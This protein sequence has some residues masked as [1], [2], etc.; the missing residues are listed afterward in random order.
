MYY[1]NI[2]KIEFYLSK[3]ELIDIVNEEGNL[4]GE[5]ELREIVHK[6]GLL[7]SAV[8]VLVY[9]SKNKI[10]IQKRALIKDFDAGKWDFV[11]GG[12]LSSGETK[13]Q[14]VLKEL[15]QEYGIKITPN[16]LEFFRK[17]RFLLKVPEKNWFD[18]EINYIY[19]L[20]HDVNIN[21][22]KLQKEEV[23]AVKLISLGYLEREISDPV[24]RISY[25]AHKD[26]SYYFEMI[27]FLKKRFK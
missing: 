15:K 9:T 17:K 22:L 21:N 12:H 25:C 18:N 26:Y 16:T 8:H 5:K 23:A 4:T 14:A 11:L 2:F 24:K 6:K 20:K 7:H 1:I 13:E 19:L 27:N 10:L 3:M